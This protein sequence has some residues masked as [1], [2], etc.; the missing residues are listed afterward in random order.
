VVRVE[1]VV[2]VVVVLTVEVWVRGG[3]RDKQKLD[4]GLM[5]E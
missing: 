3:Y 1:V 5:E 4:T 2:I